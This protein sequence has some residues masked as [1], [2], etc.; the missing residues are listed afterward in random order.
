[1]SDFSITDNV[2]RSGIRL[3]IRSCFD[4]NDSYLGTRGDDLQRSNG[5]WRNSDSKSR[6]GTG[7]DLVIPSPK[8]ISPQESRLPC[9]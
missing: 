6:S 9:A 3:H 5:Q 4:G 7:S 1:M 8:S 2:G